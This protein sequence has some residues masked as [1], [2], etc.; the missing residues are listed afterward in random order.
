[1]VSTHAG[2]FDLAFLGCLP[3]FVIM[4]AADEAEL[5]HMVA[6]CRHHRRPPL[7]RPLPAR[8]RHGPC[9]SPSEGTPLEIGRGRILRQGSTVA[10]L[11]LGTRLNRGAQA[12]DQLGAMGLTTTVADA[13]FMKPLDRDLIADLAKSHEV[14]IT[15][16]EGSIGGFGS[17]VLQVLAEN[18]H[19]DQGLKV[20]PMVLPDVFLDHDTPAKA[21]RDGGPHRPDIVSTVLQAL[22]GCCS[23]G[24]RA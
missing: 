8:R 1:M 14:L 13:R 7:P 2:S 9:R 20:R 5:A 16:E 4:A 10:I 17:H 15:I 19:L 21:L 6:N 24:N 11:S 23:P 3:D 22:A 18:G 12:A